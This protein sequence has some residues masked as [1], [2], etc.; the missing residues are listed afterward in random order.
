[1][2][3]HQIERHRL[4]LLGLR[5]ARAADRRAAVRALARDASPPAVRLL[6]DTIV[7]SGDAQAREDAVTA[8]Q[9]IGDWR[10]AA[11]VCAAWA[12]TR[13]PDLAR[14]IAERGW[15]AH[16][17]HTLRVLSALCAGRLD[18]LADSRPSSVLPLVQACQDRDPLIAGRARATLIRLG[19]PESQETLCRLASL[20]DMP[21]ARDLAIAAGFQPQDPRE[22]ALFLFL[23]SQWD[24]YRA[25]D[26]DG[27]LL[28]QAYA[29]ADPAL[30]DRIIAQAQRARMTEW[31][32]AAVASR[33]R[34]RLTEM[35]GAEW[36]VVMRALPGIPPEDVLELARH[37]P[38]LYAAPLLRHL[39]AAGWAPA[40]EHD[41]QRFEE[42]A[43]L[44][45]A[46]RQPPSTAPTPHGAWI[47][48][49]RSVA[50]IAFSPDCTL[51]ASGGADG[52]VHLW[53]MGLDEPTARSLRHPW[54]IDGLTFSHEGRHLISSSN[55]GALRLWRVRG[56][57]VIGADG[58]ADSLPL[59]GRHPVAFV[60]DSPLFA[61]G[62]AGGA[63][64][65]W[66]LPDGAPLGTFNAHQGT[67]GAL[68]ASP[69]GRLLIT[70]GAGGPAV[71]EGRLT[72][73]ADHSL[74]MWR[75]PEVSP[76][77][78][79]DPGAARVEQ[80]MFG[81]SGRLLVASDRLRLWSV[82]EGML[83]AELDG[84]AP[85]TFTVGESI[86]A[87]GPDGAVW[88]WRAPGSAPPIS[89][90]AHDR[91]AL[92]AVTSLEASADGR[93]LAAG[94]ADGTL[95]LWLL[96]EGRTLA[97]LNGFEGPVTCVAFSSDGRLLAAGGADGTLRMWRIGAAPLG[98]VPLKRLSLVDVALARELLH[99]QG[100]TDE[101]LPWLALVAALGTQLRRRGDQVDPQRVVA[102]G[103]FDVV[104]AA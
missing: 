69:D 75:L 101:E 71:V 47:A 39:T 86:A 61:T 62:G 72:H 52:A 57:A 36:E 51:L 78:L 96:P 81:A 53:E 34:I 1:M 104:V 18:L 4:S 102:A 15:V 3:T 60:P 41:R 10:V 99:N 19:R 73:P 28:G 77:G 35:T 9:T 33:R 85:V 24:A 70:A 31:A 45:G 12:A 21:I 25:A 100:T 103:A 93:L 97:T 38:A 98:L 54:A 82:P 7:G 92:R 27:T 14:V 20:H 5:P 90:E 49:Q 74:R 89:L 79:L 17:P 67:I 68:A 50:H 6:L 64:R 22:R 42:V 23:T 48:H 94:G 58:E 88:L 44:A 91:T 40:E 11:A 16:H 43:R 63:I 37:A 65:L 83:L 32:R 76:A 56:Y 29:I 95:K 59:D 8:L 26:P 13:H 55:V 84:R 2:K 87:A 80:L 30:C 46:C 66:R